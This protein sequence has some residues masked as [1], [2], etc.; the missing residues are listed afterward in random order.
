MSRYVI[1][2]F[3]LAGLH[4]EALL[5]TSENWLKSATS[6]LVKVFPLCVLLCGCIAYF[7]IRIN[8]N[9]GLFFLFCLA[10]TAFSLVSTFQQRVVL[11]QKNISRYYPVVLKVSLL[12][13]LAFVALPFHLG[14]GATLFGLN[15]VFIFV[16]F[17]Q[18][19][20]RTAKTL[21][22]EISTKSLLKNSVPKGMSSLLMSA[23]DSMPIIV[24]P[25]LLKVAN[26][27][28]FVFA[29]KIVIALTVFSHSVGT[30]KLRSE[31]QGGIK[32]INLHLKVLMVTGTLAIPFVY[33]V[34]TFIHLD[35]KYPS[36]G[37]SI[38]CLALFPSL[39]SL[40]LIL[41][42][43]LMIRNLV[44]IRVKYQ[45]FAFGFNCIFLSTCGLSHFVFNL[46]GFIAILYSV[47]IFLLVFQNKKLAKS[48]R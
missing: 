30:Y 48:F 17:F 40:N 14:I 25:H 20:R 5:N 16:H 8:M 12:R 31:S 45:L 44:S 24:A 42:N 7:E 4:I 26:F 13:F 32:P 11:S 15:A 33:M 36:L 19:K 38:I 35:K 22:P 10:E 47:E 18:L 23:L 28:S 9:I 46:Y 39:R 29:W 41:G 34:L 2:S 37:I 1:S 21:L 3:F 6:Y 43:R 27:P